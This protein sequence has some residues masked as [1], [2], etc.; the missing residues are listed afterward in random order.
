ML[1]LNT[2]SMTERASSGLWPPSSEEKDSILA[3]Q[4]AK[5]SLLGRVGWGYLKIKVRSSSGAPAPLY[6]LLR[7]TP[8]TLPS[9]L[10]TKFVL[11]VKKPPPTPP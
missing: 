4:L 6:A 5:P 2:D 8:C 7:Y 3:R 1:S 11:F 9:G 10:R